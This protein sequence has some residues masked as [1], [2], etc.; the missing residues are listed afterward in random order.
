MVRTLIR[1]YGTSVIAGSDGDE[2]IIPALGD[3]VAIP[4]D[5]VSILSTRKVAGSDVGVNEEFAG[6]LMES[7]VTGTETAIVDGIPCD[8]VVPISGHRYRIRILD[9]G[10]NKEI[11]YALTFSAT[12]GKADA[13]ADIIHALCTIAKPILD[14]ETVAEVF[15]L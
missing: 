13:A 14:T 4:G 10:A 15:W 2:E 11:G 7:Q 12:A 3:G 1:D 5:L 9:P 8:V 6:I